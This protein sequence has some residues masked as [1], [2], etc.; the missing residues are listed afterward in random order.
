MGNKYRLVG[1]V[2]P[3]SRVDRV[4]VEPARAVP[5]DDGS[6]TQYP[7]KVLELDEARASEGVELDQEQ[8]SKLQQYVVLEQVTEDTGDLAPVVDQPLNPPQTS[9]STVGLTGTTPDLESA[10][11]E[12]L[13]AEVERVRGLYPGA[14]P[15]VKGND[16]KE[17]IKGALSEF[18]VNHEV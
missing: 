15:E 5:N 9:S 11:K 17:S 14:L 18:Y 13:L 7:A 1:S 12:D 4:E 2:G 10:S 3:D 6:V 16:S 8:A